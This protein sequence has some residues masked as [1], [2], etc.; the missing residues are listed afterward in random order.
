MEIEILNEKDNPLLE[1]NEVQ[2]IVKHEGAPTPKRDEVREMLGA[3]MKKNKKLVVI[4]YL[5][6]SFGVN[7][8]SGYAKIYRSEAA[9]K[10]YEAEAILKR[11]GMV[12]EKK[13]E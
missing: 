2:F 12:E 9:A 1:R 6:S 8:S 5:K 7:T 13:E 11:N 10:K 3:M 4:D